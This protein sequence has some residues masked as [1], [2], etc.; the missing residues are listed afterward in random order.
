MVLTMTGT[1]TVLFLSG[2]LGSLGHCL[3]MCGPLNLMVAVQVRKHEMPLGQSFF[4][5]HGARIAVYAALGGVVGIVGSMLGLS[6][7][8]TVLGGVVSLGLGAAIILIGAGYLGWF[9]P[10]RL[11]GEAAWW[12]NIL[13]LLLK[14]NGMPRMLAL[15]GLNGLLP[16][17]LVYSALL[18]SASSGG[19]WS[20]ALGMTVFGLGTFPAL[21]VLDLGAGSL[22]V[23]FRQFMVRLAGGLMLLVGLQLVLRGGA[24]LHFWTHLHWN[25]IVLW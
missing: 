25:S 13:A 18:L 8:L 4:L 3:G 9:Q 11:E 21:L 17:G 19:I 12:N 2:F 20:A 1:L 7:R 10:F 24:T 15:G 5:Y 22:S 23:R 6:H 16:C 14:K